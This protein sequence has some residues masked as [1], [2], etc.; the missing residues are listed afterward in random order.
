M[1]FIL[2]LGCGVTAAYAPYG[3]ALALVGG[4][5]IGITMRRRLE[6]PTSA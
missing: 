6:T 2:A 1:A 3:Y 5:L 4:T